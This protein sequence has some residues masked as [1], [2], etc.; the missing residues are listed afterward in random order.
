[1]SIVLKS[2]INCF[3]IDG[4]IMY[5]INVVSGSPENLYIIIGQN[6]IFSLY[7]HLTYQP[8]ISCIVKSGKCNRCLSGTIVQ[9]RYLPVGCARDKYIYTNV[10]CVIEFK[11]FRATVSF[12][13]WFSTGIY[14]PVTATAGYRYYTDT[15]K[16]EYEYNPTYTISGVVLAIVAFLRWR[17]NSPTAKKNMAC[18]KIQRAYRRWAIAE[19]A[20]EGKLYKRALDRFN[21]RIF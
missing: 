17:A 8:C 5:N 14:F 16:T 9:S 20:P 15:E 6:V 7:S 19:L 1:M 12:F 3:D 11:Q 2:G 13:R 4:D 18:C 21:T 10:D